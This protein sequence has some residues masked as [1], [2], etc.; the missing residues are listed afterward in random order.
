MKY[1]IKDLRRAFKAIGYKIKIKHYTDFTA[2]E[3]ISG[4]GVRINGGNVFPSSFVAKHKVAF[5]LRA[6]M[7]G[8][9]FDGTQRV[10]I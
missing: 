10:V 1:A 3:I 4:D 2:A 7:K 6:T 8:L 5:D 9:V